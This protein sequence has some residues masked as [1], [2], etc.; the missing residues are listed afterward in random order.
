[1]DDSAVKDGTLGRNFPLSQDSP[2]KT[3]MNS[4]FLHHDIEDQLKNLP[5]RVALTENNSFS[6]LTPSLEGEGV[7]G[8]S[9][10][11]SELI[12]TLVKLR[13]ALPPSQSPQSEKLF[14]L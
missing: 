11:T 2:G 8:T 12:E 6:V 3:L 7:R 10:I 4:Q 1:M 5:D 14:V 9:H 13:S